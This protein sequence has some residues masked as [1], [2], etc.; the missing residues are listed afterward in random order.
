MSKRDH[1]NRAYTSKNVDEA[2]WFES[3]PQMSLSLI[4][5]SGIPK[6]A[7]IIDVGGGAS[8]LVDHL[9]ELG[10]TALGFLDI[11]D[12][13]LAL[14]KSRLGSKASA[15]AWYAEDVTRFL[16]PRLWDLWHDRAVFHFLTTNRDRQA[17]VE[18]MNRSVAPDGHVIIATFGLLGPS[19]C[20]G[21]PVMRYDEASL[22]RELG[23]DYTLA[24]SANH[25]HITPEG[26]AQDFIYCRFVRRTAA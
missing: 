24:E 1:W 3:S 12:E 19:R 22:Q 26:I 7:S 2:S 16:S 11:S 14:A 20:S 10:Y 25:T 9:L 6:T 4:Q 8:T 5:R 17:Y 18:V 15:V 23:P 13:S 21:L